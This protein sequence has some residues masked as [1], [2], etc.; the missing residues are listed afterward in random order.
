MVF[1][2]LETIGLLARLVG[3]VRSE[4]LLVAPQIEARPGAR[5][6]L[7]GRQVASDEE[8]PGTPEHARLALDALTSELVVIACA[9]DVLR[10]PAPYSYHSEDTP[11]AAPADLGPDQII[12]DII[13]LLNDPVTRDLPYPACFGPIMDDEEV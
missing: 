12:V 6:A 9:D 8:T 5:G 3:D 13:R 10:T 11:R 2:E 4:I 1:A 7:A